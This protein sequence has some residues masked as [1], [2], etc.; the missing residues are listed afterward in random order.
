MLYR[1]RALPPR[2]RV[3]SAPPG[4]QEHC[5][6]H[7]ACLAKYAAALAVFGVLLLFK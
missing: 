7:A 4:T 2:R 3:R 6:T 5:V 1:L